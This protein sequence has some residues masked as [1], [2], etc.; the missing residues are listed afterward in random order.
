MS[1]RAI[2]AVEGAD[3]EGFLQGLVTNDV[4]RLREGLVYAALLTP[5]G[6]YLADFLLVPDGERILI[7]VAE[8]VAPA[9][10]QRLGMYR[11]RADVR[12]VPT[13]LGVRRGTG[14]PPEGAWADPRHPALG[15]RLYGAEGGGDGTDW[16]AIRV[17]HVIPETGVELTPETYILEAG[18]ERLHGVDFR[19]GCY[20]GQEVTARMKHKTELRKG[21][22]GVAVEGAA[23]VGTPILTG[24]GREAGALYTQ[25]GGRGIAHLRFDRMGGPL[26]AGDARV[27]AGPA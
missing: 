22:V 13:E 14:A 11:L 6:K 7:D 8:G 27:V 18:F 12:L 24:D 10:V 20:V 26:A 23:P 19:K 9:L 15:W 17:A 25:S 3:R 16:D 4:G 2:V 5:Q 21:L 1:G